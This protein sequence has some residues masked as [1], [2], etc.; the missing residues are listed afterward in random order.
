P[1]SPRARS[2]GLR[3]LV[4]TS[5][6]ALAGPGAAPSCPFALSPQQ[7][8]LPPATRAQVWSAPPAT[9]STSV[10]AVEATGTFDRVSAVDTPS[11][12]AELSPQQARLRS[13]RRAHVWR[14]PLAMAR[15]P[16]RPFTSTLLE[17]LPVTP[18][19]SCPSVLRPQ[20]RTDPSS[21]R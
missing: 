5:A 6:A 2:T 16:S 17:R 21:R 13:S 4:T 19:P 8:V 9:S 12:C 1:A 15:T 3:A 14:C 18:A 11:C 20:Q 10:A 7:T